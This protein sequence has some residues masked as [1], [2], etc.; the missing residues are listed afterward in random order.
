MLQ[1]TADKILINAKIYTMEQEARAEELAVKDGKI[2]ML[3]EKGSCTGLIGEE[4]EVIDADGKAVL[5]GFIESHMHPLIYGGSLLELDCRPDSTS[6]VEEILNKVRE[7]AKET[8]EG[9]WILGFGWDESR[10]IDKRVPTIEELD[11]AAPHHPVFLKR[12]DAHNAVVNSKAFQISGID[13]TKPDPEGGKFAKDKE[14]GRLT[15]LIH[16]DAIKQ[17]KFPNHSADDLKRGMALAQEDFLKW[18][19]TTVHDKAVSKTEFTVYQKMLAEGSL[20]IRVRMW[21]WALSQMNWPGIRDHVFGSGL[22]SGFGN[23]MV[24]VQGIKYMLDGAVGGRTAAVEEPFEGDSENRGILY[25]AQEKVNEQVMAAV[26]HNLRISIHAIGERAIEQ[27]LTAFEAAAEQKPEMA[28]MRNRIE[29]CV[30]PVNEHFSRIKQ[31]GLVAGSS[32]G[33]LY[34]LGDSYAANL[35]PERVKR[36]FPHKSYKKF[37]IV[38][39]GNSDLPIT[40]GNPFLGIY[41]AVNRKTSSGRQLD[42]SEAISVYDAVKAFTVDAAY[43]GYEE[44]KTGSLKPGK[45]ADLIILSDDPFTVGEEHLKDIKVEL[46]MMNG[47]IVYRIPE[48]EKVNLCS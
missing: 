28:S 15:G 16:E 48:E 45:Y 1:V 10:M 5:P 19:L 21:M 42:K 6:S 17:I 30:L 27:A 2:L 38:A 23:D 40:T 41:A 20:K 31:L 9:E 37:G 34:E 39:P 4:T 7:A 25:M 13:E 32:I 36:A 44:D 35:G 43:S 46:T 18:G 14:T 33:F 47:D 26:N 11:E 22:Q 24:N 12:T 8:P 3:G 29:H